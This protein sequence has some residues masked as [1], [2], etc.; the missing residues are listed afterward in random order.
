MSDNFITAASMMQQYFDNT[1]NKN[2]MELPNIWKKVVS[3]VGSNN[4]DT[5]DADH[6]SF[7]EK[8][9]NNSKVI[10]L[11]NGVLLVE[12]NHPGCV[13]YLKMYQKFILTGLNR[14]V[15]ELKIRNL[16]FRVA[17]TEVSLSESYEEGL[18]KEQKILSQKIEA[19]E[20]EINKVLKQP[21]N[22][23]T[24]QLP[25]DLLDKFES[26]KESMLTN[27]GNK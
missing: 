21:D 9:A 1:L 20:K 2:A 23:K 11:K 4:T 22:H 16:A 27:S 12:A 14:A 13:Q 7:G 17:G 24:S 15:P 19:Q 25:Q 18:K 26:I 6:F 10:D 5:S 8:L 3:K